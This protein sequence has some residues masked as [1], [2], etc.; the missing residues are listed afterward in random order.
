MTFVCLF[1]FVYSIDLWIFLN[2][3]NFTIRVIFHSGKSM[4]F[5][6]FFSLMLKRNECFFSPLN[7][8]NLAIIIIFFLIRGKIRK[9][10]FGFQI[11]MR[12]LYRS[13]YI[14]KKK[15]IFSWG[16][17]GIFNISENKQGTTSNKEQNENTINEKKAE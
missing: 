13:F 6:Q 7:S 1:L 2:R 5:I 12:S 4:I 17:S 16:F 14:T 8:A 3:F 11:L 9:R 15:K 10:S